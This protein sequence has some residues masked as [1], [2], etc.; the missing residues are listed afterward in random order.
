MEDGAPVLT[1][2]IRMNLTLSAG[3]LS[4][5]NADI[6]DSIERSAM[7]VIQKLQA[8]GSDAIGFGKIAIRRYIDIPSWE[9]S[10]WATAYQHAQ[11]RTTADIRID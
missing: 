3:Q 1:A 8:A 2:A 11:V 6:A 4:R 5:T 7:S 10:D 9:K